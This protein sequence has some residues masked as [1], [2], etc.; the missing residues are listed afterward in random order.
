[1]S[2]SIRLPHIEGGIVGA[3]VSDWQFSPLVRWQSGNFS[4][5]VTGVDTA[6]SGQGDQRTIQV[7]DNPYADQRAETRADGSPSAVV[8]LERDAFRAPDQGTYSTA[9]PRTITN[10]STLTNDLAITRR[11]ALSGD[12]GL[13]FRWEIF[14][15]I[16][17]V[18]YGAPNVSFNS[19]NFGKITTT[20]DPRIMQVA[21][22]LDF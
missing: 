17:R 22:K 14:N 4:T 8:Y 1:V 15:V 9:R 20:T 13:Q 2:G 18:N 12:R 11:F 16:N 10:P 5:P 21:L 19:T 6:L 7:L 3:L